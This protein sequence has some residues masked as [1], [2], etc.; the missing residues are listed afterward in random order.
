MTARPCRRP[1]VTVDPHPSGVAG[2][3]QAVC[4]VP[5]CDWSFTSVKTACE[6]AA[7]RHRREHRDAV[8]VTQVDKLE[9]GGH[10][11]S[12]QCRAIASEH[13]MTKA[14]AD[15]WVSYHLTAVHGVVT[16]S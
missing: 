5:G 12:C 16:C 15:A 7:I 6:E 10:R 9:G 8:P 3:D 14:D 1:K 2:A 13:P 4:H 11:A